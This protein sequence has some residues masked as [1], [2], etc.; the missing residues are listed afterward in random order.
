MLSDVDFSIDQIRG[1]VYDIMFFLFHIIFTFLFKQLFSPTAIS[2]YYFLKEKPSRGKTLKVKKTGG[3]RA[4]TAHPD[5]RIHL[6]ELNQA[7]RSRIGMCFLV[8]TIFQLYLFCVFN[9]SVI[10]FLNHSG[11]SSTCSA[12]FRIL[13]FPNLES[14]RA[15]IRM[16]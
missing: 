12:S 14:R 13:R 4:P 7:Y 1:L 3:S 11:S 2:I 8:A 9:L 16:K 10:H 15:S 5:L 6:R